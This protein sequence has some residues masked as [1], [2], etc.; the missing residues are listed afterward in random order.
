M[1]RE[2]KFFDKEYYDDYRAMM[3]SQGYHFFSVLLLP[4]MADSLSNISN[5][6]VVGFVFDFS[7]LAGHVNAQT[8]AESMFGISLS[9]PTIYSR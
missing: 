7:S 9:I 6:E 4:N 1:S 5:S 3:E 8:V 2:L